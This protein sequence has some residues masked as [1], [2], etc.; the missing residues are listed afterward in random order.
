V[1]ESH[2]PTNPPT[3][4]PIHSP[5]HQPVNQPIHQPVHTLS[6][7]TQTIYQPT[8]QPINLPTYL[9]NNH[10][11]I[12]L[13][14]WHEI[15][16]LL[17]LCLLNLLYLPS[18]HYLKGTHL[19][20]YAAVLSSL[21]VAMRVPHLLNMIDT[22]FFTNKKRLRNKRWSHV[23]SLPLLMSTNIGKIYQPTNHKPMHKPHQPT[24]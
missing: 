11:P 8:H 21:L 2:Q 15:N 17:C 22:D 18:C 19:N 16:F 9:S 13:T 7:N 1:K 6:T 10:Q 5:I 20:A 24:N 14:Y 3:Y 12:N 23:W 4:P